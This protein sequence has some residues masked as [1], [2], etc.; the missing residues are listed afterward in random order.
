MHIKLLYK[1]IKGAVL[2]YFG[3]NL[4]SPMPFVYLLPFWFL[5]YHYN[6]LKLSIVKI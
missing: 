1:N 2:D 5:L 3:I 4:P 6:H